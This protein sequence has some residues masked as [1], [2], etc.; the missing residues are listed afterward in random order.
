METVLV[1]ITG[2]NLK[3]HFILRELSLYFVNEDATR[4]YFFDRPL[5]LHLTREDKQTDRYTEN[6]LGGLGIFTSIPGSLN[7]SAHRGILTSLGV[8]YSLMC[9][10]HVTHK[11]LCDLLP[12]ADITDIQSTTT[13]KYP[14]DL[15][16]AKCGHD[17]IARQCSLAKLKYLRGYV[18]VI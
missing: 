18:V 16:D 2:V 1:S 12:Y 11:F 8:R 3:H 9:V 14:A 5:G 7:Y 15:P 4:H 6:M 17:H 13:F 10:G